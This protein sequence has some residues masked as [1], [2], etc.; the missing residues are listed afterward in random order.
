MYCEE[1][2]TEIE[3][4]YSIEMLLIIGALQSILF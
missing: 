3:R 1:S 2:F 4:G